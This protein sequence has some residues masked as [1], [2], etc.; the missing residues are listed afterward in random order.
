VA[1]ADRVYLTSSRD[2][3]RF[4]AAMYPTNRG[5]CV[6]EVEPVGELAH[7]P[8][9]DEVGLSFEAPRARIVAVHELSTSAVNRIRAQV[10]T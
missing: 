9:C 7:D 3:A 10:A 6:Y 5:G 1:R 4:F 2:A 8:D